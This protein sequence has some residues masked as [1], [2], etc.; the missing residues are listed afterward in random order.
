MKDVFIS[1][2]RSD[3][4]GEAGR[5]F[6]ALSE[7]LGHGVVFRDVAGIAPGENFDVALDDALRRAGVVLVLIGPGWSTEL[8]QRSTRSERDFVRLEI[9]RALATQLRVIPVLLRG[10]GLPAPAD[11]PDDMQAL[12]RKQAL[13]L[14][15]EAW[16]VDVNRL[17]E[18]IGKPYRWRGLALRAAMTIPTAIVAIGFLVKF[19]WTDLGVDKLPLLFA[20]VLCIYA[21]AELAAALWR[22]R[23]RH[24]A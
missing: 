19:V 12:L 8:Q 5:L 10:A 4:L 17:A 24:R 6:D 23:R 20:G 14:R 2:R 21:F 16:D 11:L 7:H 22:L 18:A 13:S 9:S 1:Y 3:S 15:D